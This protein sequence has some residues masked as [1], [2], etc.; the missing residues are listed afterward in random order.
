MR[1]Q[2]KWLLH[3][4]QREQQH[5]KEQQLAAWAAEHYT[6]AAA[7]SRK[8]LKVN[9]NAAQSGSDSE[10]DE[11][12]ESDHQSAEYR[13]RSRIT[14]EDSTKKPKAIVQPW[15][16]MVGREVP[17]AALPATQP[18]AA[19]AAAAGN[20][21]WRGAAAGAMAANK[22]ALLVQDAAAAAEGD[23]SGAGQLDS[24]EAGTGSAAVLMQEVPII[25]R[26]DD[27]DDAAAPAALSRCD[28]Q[29]QTFRANSDIVSITFCG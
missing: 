20:P 2:A 5:L 14:H 29:P 9:S 28:R 10:A 15:S 13:R 4:H 23:C 27:A 18:G 11:G 6:A 12:A 25:Q 16:R 7:A 19:A 21:K 8:T 26:V 22:L 17:I 24:G 3:K 1:P